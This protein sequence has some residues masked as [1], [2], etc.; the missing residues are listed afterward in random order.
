MLYLFRLSGKSAAR[1]AARDTARDSAR[2]TARDTA[3]DSAR[4]SARDTARDT[5]RKKKIY[6]YNIRRGIKFSRKCS[7]LKQSVIA[8][9]L[10]LSVVLAT[11]GFTLL[12]RQASD[13]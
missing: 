5:V 7:M 3:R 4:D 10:Y 9:Y 12:D 1:C 6:I 8:S 11:V 2:D 13:G